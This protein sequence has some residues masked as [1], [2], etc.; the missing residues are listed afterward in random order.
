M[1]GKGSPIRTPLADIDDFLTRS[2]D[3]P[4]AKD[5]ARSR[6][7]GWFWLGYILFGIAFWTGAGFGILA[8]VAVL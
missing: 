6:Y 5:G 3:R 4:K 2:E 7:P 8:L 1:W